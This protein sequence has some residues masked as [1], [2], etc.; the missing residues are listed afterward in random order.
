MFSLL[1]LCLLTNQTKYSICQSFCI[2]QNHRN[3]NAISTCKIGEHSSIMALPVHRIKGREFQTIKKRSWR[4]KKI[5]NDLDLERVIT[6]EKQQKKSKRCELPT[7][8][9]HVLSVIFDSVL[10]NSLTENPIPSKKYD[11]KSSTSQYS[12]KKRSWTYESW[13]SADPSS[14]K[15]DLSLDRWASSLTELAQVLALGS[16]FWAMH[17]CPGETR[18]HWEHRCWS[19]RSGVLA[20]DCRQGKS[21]TTNFGA[22]TAQSKAP[23]LPIGEEG[24]RFVQHVHQLLGRA[25]ASR[26]VCR[27]FS[28]PPLI[29][30]DDPAIFH[31]KRIRLRRHRRKKS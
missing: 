29:I 22:L 4:L 18:K 31:P 3:F 9:V 11:Q 20:C 2:W 12:L 16:L 14:Y 30:P 24:V 21:M 10:V 17:S 19:A 25:F 23:G 27:P 7:M 13:T 26:P 15:H 28:C 6:Q 8:L 5:A 1:Y